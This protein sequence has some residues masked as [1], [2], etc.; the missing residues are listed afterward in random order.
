MQ[1]A[2]EFDALCRDIYAYYSNQLVTVPGE[3]LAMMLRATG[4]VW[5]KAELD[6]HTSAHGQYFSFDDFHKIARRKR[7]AALAATGV[8]GVPHVLVDDYGYVINLTV[9]ECQ[10]IVDAFKALLELRCA[11]GDELRGPVIS[12]DYFRH[13]LTSVG[14]VI[15]KQLMQQLLSDGLAFRSEMSLRTLIKLLNRKR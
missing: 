15:P 4:E 11:A 10:E 13:L 8:E 5:T 9:A 3:R 7:D 12:I 2:R 1:D 6:R 14:D